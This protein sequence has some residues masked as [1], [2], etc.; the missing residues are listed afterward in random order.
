MLITWFIVAGS[1]PI[2]RIEEY[3][4]SGAHGTTRARPREIGHRIYVS[5]ELK[6]DHH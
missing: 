2:T 4:D 3:T 6:K 1:A 5:L